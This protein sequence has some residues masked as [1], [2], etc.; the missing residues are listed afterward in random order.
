[1]EFSVDPLFKKT[2]AD[3]DEGGA[4]GLLMNHLSLDSDLRI[5]FDASDTVLE[6][7]DSEQLEISEDQSLEIDLATLQSTP[8]SPSILISAQ[9]FPDFDELDHLDICPSLKNFEFSSDKTLELPFL[10][11]SSDIMDIEPDDYLLADKTMPGIVPMEYDEGGFDGA[12]EFNFNADT[13]GDFG[14]G[15]DGWGDDH[16][17]GDGDAQGF[18]PVKDMK[19]APGQFVIALNGV[20]GDNILSY[21]DERGGKNWAGPEHWRI[22]RI[23]KGI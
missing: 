11:L 8:L 16:G 7:H 17:G 6:D 10:K 4:K 5:V 23:K 14:Q 22:Q 21:F 18:E 13:G 20:E 12:G 9:F 15:N 1:L 3:F 19:A 2:S